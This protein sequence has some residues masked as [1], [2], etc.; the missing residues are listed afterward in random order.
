[1]D[2]LVGHH[3]ADLVL[4]LPTCWRVLPAELE[5]LPASVLQAA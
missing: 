5:E 4:V 3:H 1:M 2:S